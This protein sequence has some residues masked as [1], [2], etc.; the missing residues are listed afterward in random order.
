MMRR[1]DGRSLVLVWMVLGCAACCE[2]VDEVAEDF[3][4]CESP[5]CGWM[6]LKGSEPAQRRTF[7]SAEHGLL[8]ESGGQVAKAI[9][10]RADE[11][12]LVS[13]CPTGLALA[14]RTPGGEALPPM[15]MA[16][17]TSERDN[18][19]YRLAVVIGTQV[20]VG[21]VALENTTD[22]D[23]IVDQLRTLE[24]ECD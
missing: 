14:L 20:A 2:T 15:Q 10:F 21:R 12:Q 19:W 23:C 4:D 3:E 13:N 6:A 7:H 8:I 18:A 1:V 16:A 11:V 22:Q 17:T 9:S 24:V 5:T